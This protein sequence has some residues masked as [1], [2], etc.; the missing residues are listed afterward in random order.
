[1]DVDTEG[2]GGDATRRLLGDYQTPARYPAA[3]RAPHACLFLIQ[4]TPTVFHDS[5]E[6]QSRSVGMVSE[7]LS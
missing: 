4:G 1:M 7:M 3:A 5:A 2:A 6:S